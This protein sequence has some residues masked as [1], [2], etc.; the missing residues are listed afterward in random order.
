MSNIGIDCGKLISDRGTRHKEGWCR[1][2]RNVYCL[3]LWQRLL[4]W[5]VSESGRLR[6]RDVDA[7]GGNRCRRGLALTILCARSPGRCVGHWI[8]SSARPSSEGGI[9]RPRA[10]A[11]LRLMTSSNLVGCSMGRSAG[12]AP[13]RILSTYM[14]ACRNM[15]A[16]LGP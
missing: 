10:L 2:M 11:V 16:T 6:H 12:L 9:A 8:T 7:E 13:F 15:S 14:A 5:P 3:S 4:G 1:G